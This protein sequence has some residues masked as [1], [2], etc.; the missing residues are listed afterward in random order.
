MT[1]PMSRHPLG[2]SRDCSYGSKLHAFARFAEPELRRALTDLGVPPAATVLDAGSGEGLITTWLA[3]LLDEDGV[4]VAIDL[5][6]PH[7]R[8]SLSHARIRTIQADLAACPIRDNALDL[9]WCFNVLHHIDDPAATLRRFSRALRPGGRCALA[10]S[11]FLP[12][13]YFAWDAHFD[14]RVRR[15]CHAYYRDKYG[16]SEQTTAG[17]RGLV[18]LLLDAGLSRPDARTYVI[19]RTQPLSSADR[20]YFLDAVFRGYWGEK[21]TP[22]LTNADAENLARFCN[23][24]AP[25]FCLRRPDFHHLQTLTVVVGVAA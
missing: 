19:E 21:L 15:A 6:L 18:G 16:L 11:G 1:R 14:D 7:L 13:M 8:A 22:Y 20:T 17:I 9:I 2:D 3:D 25:S 12:E 23:P 24:D 5:S 10:Q 4:L